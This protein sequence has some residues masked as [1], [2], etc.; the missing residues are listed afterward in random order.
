MPTVL[1]GSASLPVTHFASR[2]NGA[3][4]GHARPMF[5]QQAELENG[6][7]AGAT[8]PTACTGIHYKGDTSAY[9]GGTY[10][11]GTGPVSAKLIRFAGEPLDAVVG[12]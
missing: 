1:G 9:C 2:L 7:W 6:G 11:S 5:L 4:Q 12:V 8:A 3:K 10:S